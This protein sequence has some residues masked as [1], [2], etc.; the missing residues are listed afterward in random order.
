MGLSIEF[1]AGDPTA[2]GAAFLDLESDGIPSKAY[3]DLSLHLAP[4]ALDLLFDVVA[5]RTQGEVVALWDTLGAAVG[6]LDDGETGAAH[7][8][9]RPSV[10]GVGSLV[11]QDAP[12]VTAEWMRR[13]AAR[14]G[15]ELGV[16]EGAVKAIREL[17]QLCRTAVAE[18]LPVVMIWYL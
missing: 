1:Y 15:E 3:A 4:A 10:E 13:V 16:S 9:D 2:I 7:V 11:E 17:I 12:A 6:A 14:C 8:V 5:A 18:N